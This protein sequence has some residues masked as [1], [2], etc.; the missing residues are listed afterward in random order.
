MKTIG[1]AHV[2]VREDRQRKEFKGI[3]ELADSI[4]EYGLIHAPVLAF[5][6]QTLIAGER[7][8]RALQLLSEENKSFFYSGV[9]L[10]AGVLPYTTLHDMSEEEQYTIELEENIQRTDLTWQERVNAMSN[11]RELMDRKAGTSLST[12][13]FARQVTGPGLRPDGLEFKAQVVQK[14]APH[15]HD[16]EVAAAKS[17]KEALNIVKRKQGT[18]LME[19]LSRRIADEGMTKPACQHQLVEASVFDTVGLLADGAFSV[20]I[21]DPPYGIGMDAMKTQSGSDSGHV[22]TY[23]DDFT[24]AHDCVKLVAVEGFRVTTASAV[25]YMFCDIRFFPTWR[26]EFEMAGW[27]VWTQPIIWDK[28]PSGSLLGAANGPRHCYEAILMAIK[29]GKGVNTVGS[30]V[31]KIPGPRDKFHPAEKPVELYSH[32][33]RWSAVPGDRVL[34]FF[35]GSG[36]IFQAA[37]QY[38]CTATGFENNPE[39]IVTA[40]ARMEM[41]D[42]L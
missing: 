12:A 9:Q 4:L 11:L 16:P 38:Q 40:R 13:E 8:F 28:S 5:D 20:I 10:P 22:H 19:E 14:L 37:G 18:L 3:R 21:T 32:L 31:I 17:Q 30:D 6:E 1:L 42:L 2:K 15:M 26:S 7:R 35:C 24:Y 41:G 39:H 33:M 25:C 34:D 23:K 29:G 27:R 36:P